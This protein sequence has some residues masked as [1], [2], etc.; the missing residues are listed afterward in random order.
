MWARPGR[1]GL[2]A[3]SEAGKEAEGSV[4]QDGVH[5]AGFP[6]MRWLFPL[7]VR[8]R[9]LTESWKLSHWSSSEVQTEESLR[10]LRA[11]M[12][13]ANALNQKALGSCPAKSSAVV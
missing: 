12:P 5:R 2:A 11:A 3:V 13:K 7:L 8:R 9:L 1:V 4:A 10:R 6:P